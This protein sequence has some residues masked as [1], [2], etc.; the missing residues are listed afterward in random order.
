MRARPNRLTSFVVRSAFLTLGSYGA[1]LALVASGCAA[2]QGG[3]AKPSA[4]EILAGVTAPSSPFVGETPFQLTQNTIRVR[5]IVD[6]KAIEAPF[7][8][9]S[10]APMTI[11]P[12]VAQDLG[13]RTDADVTLAGPDGRTEPASVVRIPRIEIAGQTFDNVGAVVDW[14]RPPNPVACLSTVGLAGASL[15][16]AGIWQIDFHAGRIVVT[17]RLDQLMGLSYAMRLPF[18]RAD[19]SGSPRIDVALPG[20]ENA[21]LLIDL[22]FNGSLAIPPALYRKTGGTL[23]T[24]SPAQT[25]SGAATVLGNAASTLYIGL[26]AHLTIGDLRLRDLPVLTGREVSDFHVGIAFLRHFRTTI[27]WQNDYIYLQ[28]RDPESAL[29]EEFPTYG[30]TPT[31]RDDQL[32]VGAL[33]RN[34][35]AAR[36]GL[37]IDDRIISIDGK[38]VAGTF[39]SYCA[40]LDEVGL[41]GKRRRPL[42]LTVERAGK[43]HTV[44]VPRVPLLSR[45]AD[46]PQPPSR[47]TM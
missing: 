3:G 27:D 41:Y 21:S 19:A 7:L 28:R 42:S 20:V 6:G 31:L 37:A 14:V 10:G 33:W 1:A 39:E 11:A 30:F 5:A 38:D 9:D 40:L 34:G 17:D 16:R 32:V 35:S 23:T 26:L 13:L 24:A 8:L 18:H 36:E 25:G 22:G 2:F 47:T 44:T 29:Y 45:P 43:R 4:T 15:L 12:E 46:A